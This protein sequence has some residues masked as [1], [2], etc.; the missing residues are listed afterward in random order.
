MDPNLK[1]TLDKFDDLTTQRFDDREVCWECRFTDLERHLSTRDEFLNCRFA[2]LESH[3]T[4][5]IDPN[6]V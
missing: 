3:C 5:P 1:L 4:T 2:D 6:I